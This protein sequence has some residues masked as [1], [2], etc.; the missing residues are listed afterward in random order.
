LIN[1]RSGETSLPSR[2]LARFGH[3]MTMTII[4]ER[5]LGSFV[6]LRPGEGRS[7]V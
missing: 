5:R 1:G 7:V 6:A 2:R 4:N 3:T